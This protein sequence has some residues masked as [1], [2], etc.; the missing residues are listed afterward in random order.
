VNKT[1]Q[2]LI[3]A[4]G[5]LAVPKTA[6]A[7]MNFAGDMKDTAENGQ[8]SQTFKSLEAF[9]VSLEPIMAP[10]QVITSTIGAGTVES[11]VKLMDSMFKLMEQPTVTYLIEKM[12]EFFNNIINGVDRLVTFIDKFM[13]FM[14]KLA[15]EDST[16]GRVV[17]YLKTIVDYVVDFAS[18][19]P[20]MQDFIRDVGAFFKDKLGPMI[21]PTKEFLVQI[22]DF[23][24]KVF[25]GFVNWFKDEIIPWFNLYVMPLI[26]AFVEGFK[27]LADLIWDNVK[28]AFDW[29][30]EQLSKLETAFQ[31]LTGIDVGAWITSLTDTI[32]GW[33][34]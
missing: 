1:A 5:K 30:L 23:I 10:I 32:K 12:I 20:K 14:D 33:F 18:Y 11:T 3:A 24:T 15:E 28:P 16:V 19:G 21:E 13:S 31:N 26:T 7:L 4:L 25:I 17:G 6:T 2:P 8:L 27:Q 34:D 22:G 9:G 29:L